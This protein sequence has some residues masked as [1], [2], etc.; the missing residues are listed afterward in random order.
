MG[1]PCWMV[2][3]VQLCS[4]SPRTGAWGLEPVVQISTLGPQQ[5]HR[6][7]LEWWRL[8]WKRGWC[9]VGIAFV[10]AYVNMA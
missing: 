6:W 2:C 4:R 7:P 9:T 10:K 5:Q 8:C 1:R 3:L